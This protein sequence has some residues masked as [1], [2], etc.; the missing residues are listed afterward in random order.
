MSVYHWTADG[1][2]ATPHVTATVPTGWTAES[3]SLQ[4]G[5]RWI[6][7]DRERPVN[8]DFGTKKFAG[9]FSLSTWLNGESVLAGK[10]EPKT[11]PTTLRKGWNHLYFR[12]TYISWQWQ[13]SIH[14]KG[15]EGDDLSDLRYATAPQ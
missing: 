8:L 6:H 13:F 11:I 1:A 12:S 5:A 7:S 2:G 15:T 9:V 14:L 4:S 10:M 3:G